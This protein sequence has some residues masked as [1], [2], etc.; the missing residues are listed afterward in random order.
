MGEEVLQ[1]RMLLETASAQERN[2]KLLS[3]LTIYSIFVVL[4]KQ[5]NWN[6]NTR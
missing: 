4:E 6:K 3:S 5:D 2:S 1:E